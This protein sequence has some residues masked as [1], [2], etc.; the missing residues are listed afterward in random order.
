[1]W[2]EARER[3][4]ECAEAQLIAAPSGHIGDL[5]LGALQAP[6]DLICVFEQHPASVR[7]AQSPGSSVEQAQTDLG[8][9]Q[10]DLVR[11]RWLRERQRLGRSR[12]RSLVG[13]RSKRN[14]CAAPEYPTSRP[15][16]STQIIDEKGVFPAI[17]QFEI[18]PYFNNDGPREACRRHGIAI[19]AHSPL[20][21]NGE[22]L[23]NP[24]I[25]QIAAAHDKSVAQT[26]LRWH[27]QHGTIAIPKSAR[28]D[29]MA[30]NIDIFDFELSTAEIAAIDALDRGPT[31]RVGPNPDTYEGI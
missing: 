5:C 15:P 27:I 24:T 21:H 26:L 18:H 12:E 13:N 19:E 10:C 8:F 3:G 22:P 17:N 11:H 2:Y 31:G 6:G 29:R 7:E 30:E 28:P 16:T 23:K 14:A 9:Q 20:G 4:G 25:A 1:M